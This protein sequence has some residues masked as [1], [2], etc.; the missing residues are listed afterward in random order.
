MADAAIPPVVK[1]M[2]LVVNS[3]VQ[4]AAR[5]QFENLCR[6]QG[7]SCRLSAEVGRR[8]TVLVLDL[9][10]TAE[11]IA[12][13]AGQIEIFMHAQAAVPAPERWSRAAI[14]AVSFLAGL[15][16]VIVLFYVIS[17]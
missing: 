16:S 12:A 13:A 1:R 10:G 4:A 11:G 8:N 6:A 7:V 17:G 2:A 5:A 3:R 15:A 14:G 9:R